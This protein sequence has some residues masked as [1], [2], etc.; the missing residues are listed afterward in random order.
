MMSHSDAILKSCNVKAANRI[1]TIDEGEL[2]SRTLV[3]NTAILGTILQHHP[4]NVL[5][6]GCGEGW[7]TRSL[8]TQGI[9]ATLTAE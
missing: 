2:E 4:K 5:D 7:L 8:Q 9:A 1:R 6:N 3:T